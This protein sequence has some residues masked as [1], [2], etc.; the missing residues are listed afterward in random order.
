MAAGLP[1]PRPNKNL[2]HHFQC[3][4]QVLIFEQLFVRNLTFESSPKS[5]IPLIFF[6]CFVDR[7]APYP[8][9]WH[10]VHFCGYLWRTPCFKGLRP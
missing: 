3:R 6:T 2:R 10:K 9:K 4:P 8:L 1:A 7:M 5:L